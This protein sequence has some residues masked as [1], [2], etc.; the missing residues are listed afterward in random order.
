[1]MNDFDKKNRSVVMNL[2]TQRFGIADFDAEDI[3]QDAW[4]LLLDKLM[5]GEL[6]GVPEKLLAYIMRVC[7]LK[8]HEYL[9]KRESLYEC[10]SLDD[11][12]LTAERHA[13][14]ERDVTDWMTYAEEYERA[15]Q[16]KLA[17][18]NYEVSR[19][20]TRQRALLQ[21]YYYDHR[22]MK[23]LA[24]MLGYSNED[25][26]KNTKKRIIAS[27]RS[28]IQRQEEALGN[29]LSPVAIFIWRQSIQTH[30]SSSSSL[31]S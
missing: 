10:I 30:F 7:S 25:V 15:E 13:A 11:E 31:L 18:M 12:S 21:G 29:G 27:L 6:P 22:S 20:N 8:A 3:L 14:I 26:A 5:V 19:L 2:L 1:M 16:R 23:E 4:V 24:V 9:R 17:L 28:G